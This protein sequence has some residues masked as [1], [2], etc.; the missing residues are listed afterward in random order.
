MGSC[1]KFWKKEYG[2]KEKFFSSFLIFLFEREEKKTA[3]VHTHASGVGV[4]AVEREQA[5]EP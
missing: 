3:R 4:G 1:V 2:F 5:S